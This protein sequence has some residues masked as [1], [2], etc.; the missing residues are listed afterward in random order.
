MLAEGVPPA[1]HRCG[2]PFTNKTAAEM[3]ARLE[4]MVGRNS[5][6][7]STFHR[8]C[9]RLLRGIASLVGLSENFTIYDSDDAKKQLE[10]AVEESKEAMTHVEPRQ[11]AR[12]QL[13]KEPT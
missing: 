10:L 4:R 6:W 2:S 1:K 11:I 5:V 7:M 9:G 3:K 13:G 12:H 8:F